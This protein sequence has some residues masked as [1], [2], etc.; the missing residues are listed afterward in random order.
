[1]CVG[2]R[3][4]G[5]STVIM[6]ESQA[7]RESKPFYNVFYSAVAGCT[8]LICLVIVL[9]SVYCVRSRAYERRRALY[10][11]DQQ[12]VMG[13]YNHAPRP[14]TRAVPHH[15]VS[16]AEQRLHNIQLSARVDIN[17]T[18]HYPHPV[19]AATF[20][21]PPPSYDQTV[22]QPVTSVNQRRSPPPA[23]F[24]AV[25]VTTTGDATVAAETSDDSAV[26]MTMTG[27]SHTP[28]ESEVT[29]SSSLL[30]HDAA[31]DC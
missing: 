23:Y 13:L 12:I 17:I 20:G 6:P 31:S 15:Y 27:L 7:Q 10:S 21:A 9:A 5:S 8:G 25:A 26:A 16:L 22:N 4:F 24:S 11:G 3:P 18:S 19:S 30:R 14:H 29:T 1:M 28:G 2:A